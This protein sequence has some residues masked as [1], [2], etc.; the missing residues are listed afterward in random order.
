[1]AVK[2][3]FWR[4][5]KSRLLAALSVVIAALVIGAG[6]GSDT[7]RSAEGED[8]P[9]TEDV[10]VVDETTDDE[11]IDPA[12]DADADSATADADST[13]VAKDS[14]AAPNNLLEVITQS[15]NKG[16][17]FCIRNEISTPKD[18]TFSVNFSKADTFDNGQLAPGETRCG[19][20]TFF[21]GDDVVGEISFPNDKVTSVPFAASN[22]WVGPPVAY[23]TLI[24]SSRR[25]VEG[26]ESG[27]SEGSNLKE[28]QE[29]ECAN[30]QRSGFLSRL[31]DTSWKEW[32]FVVKERA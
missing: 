20:G 25:I 30:P 31:Y 7:A 27:F 9:T 17:R 13:D 6:C 12:D 23:A 1:V 15:S 28:G 11:S 22:P 19:E 26:C 5:N 32:L 24:G 14:T 10:V 2:S 16:S 29:T 21:T 4:Q 18:N 3:E 8:L